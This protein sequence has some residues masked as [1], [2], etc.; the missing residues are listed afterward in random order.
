MPE[1]MGKLG[2]PVNG[3]E[4][5]P[6]F[7]GDAWER[8]D[9]R[10]HEEPVRRVYVP[11]ASDKTRMRPLGIPVLIDRCHQAR[12]KN[13]LE[14]EWEARFEPR[15]YGF[16]PGRS[17]QDAVK[18][19]HTSSKGSHAKRVWALDADLAAAFDR[20]GH[21]QLLKAIGDFPG[22]GMVAGWLKAG[23]FEPGK[24]FAPTGEGTPQG[25]VISPLLMNVALHGLEEAA[26]VRYIAT[27]VRAGDI[28]PGSPTLIRYA[29][30]LV[31]LCHSQEQAGQVK[32]RLAEWL[33]P[34]GLAFN[35][36]KTQIVHLSEGF[37]LLGFN[38]RRYRH[39]LLVKPSKAAVARLRARLAAEMRALRGSNALAVIAKLNP[40]IKGWAAYYRGAVSKRIFASLDHYLRKL[41]YQWSAWSH[42]DKPKSWIVAR[43]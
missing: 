18:A 37:D 43:Y 8:T 35:E 40:I 36:G 27:G 26:G 25:G 13:A 29:D 15:S 42:S 9:W 38:V 4:G 10:H 20:I 7:D 6:P 33:A 32:A 24:G 30:D 3:P 14:P 28:K 21:I 34:R 41:L 22:R 31:V 11:K 2:T 1:L 16:R 39:K 5:L 12:V 17:C 23:V 19:I